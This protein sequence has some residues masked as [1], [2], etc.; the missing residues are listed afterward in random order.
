MGEG[1]SFQ[2]EFNKYTIQEDIQFIEDVINE[3]LEEE[4]YELIDWHKKLLEDIFAYQRGEK[5]T[6]D[7]FFMIKFKLLKVRIDQN[8]K[9]KKN[10]LNEDE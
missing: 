6:E 9:Q 1:T 8:I 4:N 7:Q 10:K 5:F 2:I 3:L